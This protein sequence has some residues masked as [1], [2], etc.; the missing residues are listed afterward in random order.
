M[1]KLIVLLLALNILG[2]FMAGCSGGDAADDTT[3]PA[4][5]AK[6]ADADTE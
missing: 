1:K 4:D 2:A 3:A 5:G 6:D